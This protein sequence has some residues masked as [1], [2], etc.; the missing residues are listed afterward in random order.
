MNNDLRE[1]IA[2]APM[3]GGLDPEHVEFLAAQSRPIFLPAGQVLFRRGTPS[4][5]FYMVREGRMQL[6][7]SNSEGVVK[8]VEILSPGSAFG[9]A[10]MFL[11]EPY[12]VDATALADT[13]LLFVPASAVDRV[14]DSDPAMARIMLASMARRLQSKVQDIAMLSLQ[15]ATQRIIAYM[16]GAAGA[17]SYHL[18]GGAGSSTA[19]G[20]DSASVELPALKQ[21]LASRLGMTPETFSRA[22]RTLSAEGL[23]QV[24]GSVV[25]IPDVSALDAHARSQ[26]IL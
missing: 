9:H 6:S 17:G 12:P 1:A 7:V 18:A 15:S 8:V 26:S 4:T 19:P 2:C 25:E 22:I 13:Q 16:L 21:V 10:V 14:L 11:H 20:H 23:I 24:N 3:F 5:G